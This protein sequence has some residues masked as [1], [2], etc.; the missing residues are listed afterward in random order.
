MT[1]KKDGELTLKDRLSRLSYVQACKLLGAEGRQL[2]QREGKHD[3]I[4]DD[5]VTLGNDR[6]RLSLPDAVTTITLSSDARQRL[7]WNCTACTT[8][9][10]HVGAA[11]SVILEEKMALRSMEPAKPWTNYTL[12]STASGKSYRVALRGEQRGEAI[13]R[14]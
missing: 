11:F 14:S 6:F 2:I 13:L 7:R 10:D 4:L 8:A 9:C 3:V 12:T 1:T 5:Q